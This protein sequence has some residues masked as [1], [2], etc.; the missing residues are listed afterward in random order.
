MNASRIV[1][2]GIGG[3]LLIG[4]AVMGSTA[5]DAAEKPA[6]G[7][8]SRQSV[9]LID[10]QYIYRNY[11]RFTDRMSELKAKIQQS[12]AEVKEK[13]ESLKVLEERLKLCTVGTPEHTEL[14]K[15]ITA[16]K[17]ALGASVASQKKMFLREEARVYYECYQEILEEVE[18]HARKHG[19]AVVLQAT[20]TPVN[21]GNPQA[22]LQRINRG[23]VWWD[24]RYDVTRAVLQRL[25]EKPK[26]SDPTEE[27]EQPDETET[28]EADTGKPGRT[29][30]AGG[31]ST[32]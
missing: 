21:V 9:G 28:D 25:T 18:A 16:G 22:V 26:A 8:E 14:D 24:N 5:Q 4:L 12:E 10:V 6:P 19:I 15:E 1:P 32:T 27:A 17:A 31:L 30:P 3:L 29:P 23:I 13:Q 7:P 2:L 11:P 20:D